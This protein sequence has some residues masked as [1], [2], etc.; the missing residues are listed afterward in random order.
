MTL[1][2]AVQA[3]E[4]SPHD[5]LSSL[6]VWLREIPLFIFVLEHKF[7]SEVRISIVVF[8]V[9]WPPNLIFL[10]VTLK[11]FVAPVIGIIIVG[12]TCHVAVPPE[13]EVRTLPVSWF[14]NID[15]VE[16]LSNW[17]CPNT[18]VHPDKC[19]ISFES[20]SNLLSLKSSLVWAILV[21]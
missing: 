5:N 12:M 15:N 13:F 6:P 11:P 8:P 14:G 16:P 21:T 7:K 1:I 19:R 9:N 2:L 20:C 10:S 17:N 3:D 4:A 18:W